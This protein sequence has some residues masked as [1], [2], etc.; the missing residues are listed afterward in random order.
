MKNQFIKWEWRKC[1]YIIRSTLSLLLFFISLSLFSQT[2]I[3][4]PSVTINDG[5]IIYIKDN[6]SVTQANHLSYRDQNNTKQDSLYSGIYITGNALIYDSE[7]NRSHD[8][9]A[10]NDIRASSRVTNNKKIPVSAKK[11]ADSEKSASVS[12]KA[13]GSEHN[14]FSQEGGCNAVMPNSG[15][16][17]FKLYLEKGDYFTFRYRAYLSTILFADYDSRPRSITSITHYSRPPPFMVF[18]V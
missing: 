9:D 15:Q 10:L 11:Q 13:S 3:D 17:F 8:I 7:N 4:N 16:T 2:L 18:F 14:L 5:A 6:V 1:F 12:C